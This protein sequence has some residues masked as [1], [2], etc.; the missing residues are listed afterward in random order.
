MAATPDMRA[1]DG[2]RDKVAAALREHAAQGRL[3]MEE[4]QER[5]E[6]VYQGRTYGDLQR[7]T[8]DLPDIDLNARPAAPPA[9]RERPGNAQKGLRAAWASWAMAV[10]VTTVIWAL[11]DFGGYFWPMWVAGPWGAILLV[12][13]LFGGK[14]HGS[15]S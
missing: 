11:S 15:K 3:T 5:L 14:N 6:L 12:S 8:A 1:S 4:F 10:A 7:L 2:D 13:T 9:E